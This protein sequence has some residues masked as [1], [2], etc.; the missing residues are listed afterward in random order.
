MAITPKLISTGPEA[1]SRLRLA[2]VADATPVREDIVSSG[3]TRLNTRVGEALLP[4]LQVFLAGTGRNYFQKSDVAPALQPLTRL[5]HLPKFATRYAGRFVSWLRRDHVPWLLTLPWLARD[6]RA[7][8]VDWIFCPCGG[9]P[10]E[11]E[12]VSALARRAGVKLALYL[13]DDFALGAELEG[14]QRLMQL[15]R[16][17]V[18]R[19]L[20]AADRLFSISP[21]MQER[22]QRVYGLASTLLPLPYQAQPRAA[23]PAG[24][25]ATEVLFLG[26]MS[27]FYHGPLRQMA[28]AIDELNSE[29]GT[30]LTLRF[31]L[32]GQGEAKRVLGDHACIRSSPLAD[33]PALARAVASSL[34]CYA[35]YSF[36]A[37]QEEMVACSFP[38]KLMDYL[39]HGRLVLVHSPAYGSAARYFRE[40][41]LPLI[42]T[43]A[44]GAGLKSALLAQLRQPQDHHPLY[45][46][47]LAAN[48]GYERFAATV[49]QTLAS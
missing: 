18:P 46:A 17:R 20:G 12:F 28:Q 10:E 42:V 2:V 43:D 33:Q 25:A 16:D 14:N 45:R 34:V 15:A 22:L 35:P 11:L 27:H 36:D 5:V 19:R 4:W 44:D 41:G 39:C 37:A 21:G 26:S 30:Q 8:R 23:L 29:L 13:V 1:E 24:D 3:M 32:P 7:R 38:S 49:V 31:T 6:L 9:N 47:A 48:H 40:Q